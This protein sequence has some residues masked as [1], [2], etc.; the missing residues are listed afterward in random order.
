V[1]PTPGPPDGYETVD[2]V[3]N[4]G[5]M[6]GFVTSRA[7]KNGVRAPTWPWAIT[8]GRSCRSRTPAA[9]CARQAFAKLLAPLMPRPSMGR[10]PAAARDE[11]DHEEAGARRRGQADLARVRAEAGSLDDVRPVA[12]GHQ[13]L[14]VLR[15]AI[16]AFSSHA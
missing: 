2:Q 1:N 15:T 10:S 13:T 11:S 9:R 8:P 5:L 16:G 14:S 12:D 6:D 7:E 3:M 4:V